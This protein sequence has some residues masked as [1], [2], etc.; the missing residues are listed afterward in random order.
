M[1]S[2]QNK[3]ERELKRY[4]EHLVSHA[5]KNKVSIIVSE[6]QIVNSFLQEKGKVLEDRIR[7]DALKMVKNISESMTS[8]IALD[9]AKKYMEDNMQKLFTDYVEENKWAKDFMASQMEQ[10]KDTAQVKIKEI[11]ESDVDTGPIIQAQVEIIDKKVKRI[12][13]DLSE[14]VSNMIKEYKSTIDDLEEKVS[15][16]QDK[17]DKLE[18]QCEELKAQSDKNEKNIKALSSTVYEDQGAI[19]RA[20]YQINKNET[21]ITPLGIATVPGIVA[22]GLISMFILIAHSRSRSSRY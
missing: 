18:K 7:E 13:D 3:L 17:N 11:V 8:E 16:L 14:N 4:V 12:M 20:F 6:D 5:F 10:I 9:V 19:N 22:F 15:E 21:Y 2:L 1:E